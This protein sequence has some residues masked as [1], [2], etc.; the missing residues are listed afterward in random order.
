M[1]KRAT[2]AKA[3]AD[4]EEVKPGE[5][6]PRLNTNTIASQAT[7]SGLDR[8][9]EPTSTVASSLKSYD[10][11]ERNFAVYRGRGILPYNTD[12]SPKSA[13]PMVRGSVHDPKAKGLV[14]ALDRSDSKLTIADLKNELD[15][16]R[17]I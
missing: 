13:W 7:G 9:A 1:K 4:K 14:L 5:F 6:T 12:G 15:D 17:G 10:S 16:R 2:L 11:D 8:L 3:Q